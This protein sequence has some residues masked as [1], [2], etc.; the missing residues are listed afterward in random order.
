MDNRSVNK[1]HPGASKID[2]EANHNGVAGSGET[3]SG[4]APGG[5]DGERMGQEQEE[6]EEGPGPPPLT[7]KHSPNSAPSAQTTHKLLQWRLCR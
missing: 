3:S 1:V 5:R 2:V 4:G 6:E 7:G